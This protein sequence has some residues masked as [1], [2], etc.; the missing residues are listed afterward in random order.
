MPLIRM[1]REKGSER[2]K[3]SPCIREP[4]V[5]IYRNLALATP[6]ILLVPT[7]GT[8]FLTMLLHRNRAMALT[9]GTI[10]RN[11]L[12]KYIP[13]FTLYGCYKFAKCIQIDITPYRSY[14]REIEEE[15]A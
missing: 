2:L 12:V 7:I 14:F 13:A 4:S 9:S 11:L 8:F 3:N 6:S 10:I 5:Q 15:F 1:I